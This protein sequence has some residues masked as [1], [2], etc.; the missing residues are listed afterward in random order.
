MQRCS[1]DWQQASTLLCH[2]NASRA[3]LSYGMTSHSR[4]CERCV[5]AA[6]NDC[7][8]ADER[9]KVGQADSSNHHVI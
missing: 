8:P 4:S 2:V 5:A 1:T 7:L 6:V 9:A 3:Q